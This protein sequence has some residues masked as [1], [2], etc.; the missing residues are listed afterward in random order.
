MGFSYLAYKWVINKKKFNK[1]AQDYKLLNAV[2]YS[3]PKKAAYA[4]TLYGATFKNDSERHL[5]AYENM[6][7]KL[8][9]YKYKK[10]VENFDA[11][12]LHVIDLY[13][14]MIDV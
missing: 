13:K 11:D 12:T 5:R 2:D 8:E 6:I 1:R 9:K 3:N 4:L 14:G 7:E 10:N